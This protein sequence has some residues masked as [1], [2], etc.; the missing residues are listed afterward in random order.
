MQDN[1]LLTIGEATKLIPHSE[2]TL[3]RDIRKGKVSASKDDNGNTIVDKA[4]L[5]RV[6]GQ[7]TDTP[8]QE[9][10]TDSPKIVSLL[11]GQVQELQQALGQA[12][13]R[14]QVLMSLLKAEKQ[15]KAEIK[16]LMPPPDSVNPLV[17]SYKERIQDLQSQLTKAEQRETA[18][19]EERKAEHA[20]ENGNHAQ[21]GKK[22]KQSI[23]GY[24]RLKR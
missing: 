5:A 9:T 23:L 1:H 12:T 11:E 2:S 18:L 24:F 3:R 15:E 13:E 14:E 19:I 7:V 22:K 17:E 6:Y 20:E 16:A 8:V 10:G 21:N 4:E